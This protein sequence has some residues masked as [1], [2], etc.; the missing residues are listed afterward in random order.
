MEHTG[1][2]L[3][4]EVDFTTRP[5]LKKT[6]LFA[7]PLVLSSVLQLLYSA[8]DIIVLGRFAGD[9]SE[10]AVAA[11]G[12]T[13]ALINL[14]TNLFI[15][16]SVGA[17]A[18]AARFVGARDK[19]R[20]SK[21]VHTSIAVSVISGF[22]VGVF[23]FFL[24]KTML[25][26]MDTPSSVLELSALYLKIYFIGVPFN[27]LY[28]FASSILRACGD[29]RR[30]LIALAA[31]G[32]ANI[33][34]NIVMVA[35]LKMSVAGVGVATVV[36]EVVA[37][38]GVTAALMRRKDAAKLVLKRLRIHKAVLWDIVK[39][40]VPAGFQGVIFSLSNVIIQSSI[41]GFGKVAMAGNAAAGNLEG[42][43]Y[44]AMNSVAQACLTVAGQN[45]GAAKPKNIDL[46][47]VQC[48]FLVTG[49]GVVLGVGVWL[50]SP[51]LLKLYGCSGEALL[52]GKE[53]LGV[54]CTMYFLCGIME[55]LVSALR[56]IGRS[57]TPMLVSIAGVCGVRILW[58]YTVF[59]AE[60]TLFILQ[61]SYPV[62]WLFTLAVHLVCYLV[63]RKKTFAELRAMQPIDADALNNG[64][65]ACD[66]TESSAESNTQ[67]PEAEVAAACNAEEKAD[68][69]AQA[70][71]KLVDST[72]AEQL[73]ENESGEEVE[74]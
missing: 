32:V 34:L 5:L 26:W 19:D 17:L 24:S 25:V 72:G 6:I 62:S 7:L 30:P 33:G 4:A 67:M 44:V 56:A 13:G 46:S 53:R 14:I 70:I 69:V 18:V 3:R 42:F 1:K 15:G 16:L 68:R 9:E 40:G 55:V 61:V 54:I 39:I 48:L 52:I 20:L 38:I 51:F 71:E 58:I 21:S 22:I 12:S 49:T 2:R 10:A 59:R 43:V 60:H 63:A 41:N 23:G 36:S 27:F 28:N 57:V 73:S 65:A 29:T 37:A 74:K 64:Q 45:Y 47:L 35:G 50:L 66:I 31:A 8:A 11:V